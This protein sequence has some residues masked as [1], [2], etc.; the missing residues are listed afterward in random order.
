MVPK[1][2]VRFFTGSYR[3]RQKL[4]NDWGADLYV[5]HHF[6]SADASQ[7]NQPNY[8]LVVVAVNASERSKVWGQSYVRKVSALL[9]PFFGATYAPRSFGD[10]HFG[11]KVGGFSA[12]GIN[13]R[14]DYNLRFTN[15]PAILLEP[16]FVSNATHA[17][18]ITTLDGKSLFAK[19]LIQSIQ[20][21]LPDGGKVAFSV[22]HKGK[23]S[24]P[25]DRGAAVVGHPDTSEA[26][27]AE[28]VLILAEQLLEDGAVLGVP[29]EVLEPETIIYAGSESPSWAR[30]A[31][32][33]V[34]ERGIMELETKGFEGQRPVTRFELAVI[35]HRAAKLLS[36]E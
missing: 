18:V 7:A 3:T 2:D 8:P 20:E 24:K 25:N 5:E 27:E 30:E 9:G 15:M 11:V 34:T 6:N 23:P 4:A 31:V 16:A 19:A 12:G 28:K 35:I 1:Y 21:I 26:D 13:N 10:P 17:K 22:G 29:E 14:G 32:E 33:F 36:K